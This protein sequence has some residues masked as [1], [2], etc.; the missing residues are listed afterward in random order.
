MTFSGAS[1]NL[2]PEMNR[3]QRGYSNFPVL[4]ALLRIAEGGI[5]KKS[6]TFDF[7][8]TV[9]SL[10]GALQLARGQVTMPKSPVPSKELELRENGSLYNI[11]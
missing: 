7:T 2:F 8:S 3:R 10:C 11:L 9:V 1:V 4:G 6:K 5:L